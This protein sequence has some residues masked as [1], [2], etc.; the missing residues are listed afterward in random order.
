MANPVA[1]ERLD[2]VSELQAELNRR[3]HNLS[4]EIDSISEAWE[5]LGKIGGQRD[6]HA[7]QLLSRLRCHLHDIARFCSSV[8]TQIDGLVKNPFGRDDK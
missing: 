6:D 2:N 8:E 5:T 1:G 7:A 3:H 4:I